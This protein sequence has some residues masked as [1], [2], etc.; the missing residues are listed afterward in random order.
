MVGDDDVGG[1][2]EGAEDERFGF[3]EGGKVGGVGAFGKVIGCWV[4]FCGLGVEVGVC[5]GR[6]AGEQVGVDG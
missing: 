2:G 5:K 6:A 3:E 1:E 4:W